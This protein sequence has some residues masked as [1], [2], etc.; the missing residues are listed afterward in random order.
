MQNL[1]YKHKTE[2]SKDKTE[3]LRKRKKKSWGYKHTEARKHKTQ[4]TN[5]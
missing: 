5:T 3:T 4:A 1:G 2:A